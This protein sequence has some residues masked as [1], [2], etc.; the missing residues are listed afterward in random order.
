MAVAEAAKRAYE[1]LLNHVVATSS[2]PLLSKLAKLPFLRPEQA[3]PIVKERS[4]RLKQFLS[5]SLHRINPSQYASFLQA[6]YP[7]R[8]SLA[9]LE[10]PI[11]SRALVNHSTLFKHYLELPSPGVAHMEPQDFEH[12]MEEVLDRR[13]FVK[14]NLLGSSVSGYYTPLQ[15]VRGYKD[16]LVKREAHVKMCWIVI[17]DLKKAKIPISNEEQDQLIYMS[18]FRDR[19]DVLEEVRA[20]LR[21]ASKAKYHEKVAEMDLKQQRLTW[22][23]YKR[24]RASLP[25]R[26]PLSSVNV[27]L[28]CAFRNENAEVVDD[29]L[30]LIDFGN[31]KGKLKPDSETF[32]TL[33][34]GFTTK[35]DFENAFNYSSIA[36]DKFPHIVDVKVANS[37]ILA[38]IAGGAAKE[39]DTIVQSIVAGITA[40]LDPEEGYLKRLTP[41]DEKMYEA[42]LKQSINDG[43]T[44]K[45]YPTENTLFPLLCYYSE[46]QADFANVRLLLQVIEHIC[47]L[48]LSTRIFIKV[49]ESFKTSQH[50]LDDAKDAVAKVV[51]LHDAYHEISTD[52]RLRD[53]LDKLHMHPEVESLLHEAL[54]TEETNLPVE[55]G[56]FLK[57]LDRLV[58]TI[59]DAFILTTAREQPDLS[60][61]IASRKAQL[62]E[63][64]GETR[65]KASR[66]SFDGPTSAEL[67]RRDELVYIKKGYLIDLL[68][69]LS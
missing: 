47:H 32:R 42:A 44:H 65:A 17:E 7:Q 29:L 49:F 52:L 26:L 38:L 16:L 68:D 10:A 48:P 30:K 14:P 19:K 53:K 8:R 39:A 50:S 34:Y 55:Q 57:L 24:L 13:D 21:K 36:V 23:T 60:L 12:F 5:Q 41:E 18:F 6:L 51:G 64:L 28:F 58:L 2:R 1:R 59:F 69:V 33:I 31:G 56:A 25:Q 37:M 22:D 46:S 15:I 9:R 4:Q 66:N 45:L 27:L 20:A 67:Y 62:F 11:A 43:A 54:S 63:L 3:N 61:E 35:G 40:P